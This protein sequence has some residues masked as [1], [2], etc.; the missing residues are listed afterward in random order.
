MGKPGGVGGIGSVGRPG[1]VGGVGGNRP[2][3]LPAQSGIGQNALSN[4]THNPLHRAVAHL[5]RTGLLQIGLA[6]ALAVI[7]LPNARPVPG[8]KLLDKVEGSPVILPV[9]VAWAILQ[10][11]TIPLLAVKR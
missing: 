10:E 8:N 9:V 3:T 2:S 6:A 7:H 11:V 1:G 4:W 5:I